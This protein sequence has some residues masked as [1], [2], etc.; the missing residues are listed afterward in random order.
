MLLPLPVLV[1]PPFAMQFLERYNILTQPNALL[2][3]V[4]SREKHF[5]LFSFIKVQTSRGVVIKYVFV[6]FLQD[7]VLDVP[8]QT[9]PSCP[10][11]GLCGC[12]WVWASS[13]YSSLP[14]DIP[15]KLS[16]CRHSMFW[17]LRKPYS[18]HCVL[19]LLSVAELTEFYPVHS[20]SRL[21]GQYH[22]IFSNT[23]KIEKTLFGW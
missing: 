16:L 10:S 4:R 12:I 19:I 11:A 20:I 2:K 22:A 6:V 5:E 18:I 3:P 14:T 1:I 15:G 7:E 21:K 9:S 17:R 8:S 13:R 23:L